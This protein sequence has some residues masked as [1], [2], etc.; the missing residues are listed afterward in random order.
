M[1]D[2]EKY[3]TLLVGKSN[4]EEQREDADEKNHHNNSAC[5]QT[6]Q[7]YSL[8]YHK[9]KAHV[10]WL[11]LRPAEAEAYKRFQVGRCACFVYVS[12][13]CHQHI[14]LLVMVQPAGGRGQC[15]GLFNGD[16]SVWGNGAG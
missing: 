16:W 6:T 5:E 10:Q 8:A 12:L 3:V 1:D 2:P 9:V 11:A 14:L 13:T 7:S 4:D 15:P